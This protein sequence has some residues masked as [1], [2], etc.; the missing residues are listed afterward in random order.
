MPFAIV[1]D[2]LECV[3]VNAVEI[4]QLKSFLVWGC[5][6][7]WGGGGGR[8]ERRKQDEVK[9]RKVFTRGK[10]SNF[11]KITLLSSPLFNAVVELL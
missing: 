3:C 2:S 9:R 8:F 6:W 4:S 11:D 10:S 1:D 7:W 5:G